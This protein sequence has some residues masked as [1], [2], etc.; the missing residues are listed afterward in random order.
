MQGDCGA[1]LRALPYASARAR[2][3]RRRTVA[4]HAAWL[5]TIPFRSAGPI[6][7]RLFHVRV[8]NDNRAAHRQR[9]TRGDRYLAIF[10]PA[11]SEELLRSAIL[12]HRL[13]VDVVALIRQGGLSGQRPLY[14]Y[15]KPFQQ[16]TDLPQLLGNLAG[17]IG[18]VAGYVVDR[19][20]WRAPSASIHVL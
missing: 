7:L 15:M 1:D 4:Y 14:P 9:A 2:L 12:P 19:C 5:E 18:H 16:Y 3:P 8:T 10:S 11:E 17:E 6:R 20:D 13:H